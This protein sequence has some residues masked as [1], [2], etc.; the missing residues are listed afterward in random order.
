MKETYRTFCNQA[1]P[2]FPV[3]MQHWFLDAV[4][5]AGSWDAVVVENGEGVQAVM[6]F[7]IKKKWN[8]NYVAMPTLCRFMGPYIIPAYRN[9]RNEIS[10]LKKLLDQLPPL[11]SFEQ[12]FNYTAQNWL[13]FYWKKFQQ[14]TRYSYRISLDD[15]DAV[16]QNMWPD[17]RNQK[18][19]KARERVH[20]ETGSDLGEF[21]RIHNLSFER[22]NL[23]P[24][25]AFPFFEQLIKA[26]DANNAGKL[27]YTKDQ[28]GGELHAVAC[29]IWDKNSAYFLLAGEDPTLRNSGAGILLAWETIRYAAEELKLPWFDF[30]GSMI[31]P[32]A[33]VRK[34]FGASETPY[35]RVWKDQHW[36]WK[37]KRLVK[38]I[39]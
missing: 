38:K 13:P 39:W 6:P 25:F 4:C 22:Q 23:K 33:R 1:P 19:K 8:K 10:L 5:A 3:F 34:Q 36:L 2:D 26:L 31:E 29:L 32:I 37:M 17:Y 16:Y 15:L 7:F 12:D 14:T 24:P 18:I 30:A 11:A 27:F 35:L 20:I 28:E 21:Y 9:N